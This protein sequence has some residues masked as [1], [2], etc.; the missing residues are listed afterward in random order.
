MSR[1][2]SQ[3]MM[4]PKLSHDEAVQYLVEYHFGRLSPALNA[5][6]EAHV[7]DC[8]LCQRQ[9]LAHA[10]TEKRD[11]AR[12]IKRIR[13]GK[14]RIT[15][16]G[17]NF[18]VLLA[19]LA[20]A[21]L[22]VYQLTR[23]TSISFAALFGHSGGPGGSH[24]IASPPAARTLTPRLTFDV[25]SRGTVALA[26]SPDGKMVAGSMMQGNSPAVVL[27]NAANG[28]SDTTLTWPG[29]SVPGAVSWSPD[30]EKVVATDGSMI[31][32]WLLPDAAPAWTAPVP[33]AIALRTYDAQTGNIAQSPAPATA[34]ANGTFLLW[35]ADGQVTSAP[36]GAAGPSGV[37]APGTPLIGLWQSSG[38]H[39]VPDGNGGVRVGIS[40]ADVAGHS[41]LVSWSPDS[42]YVMWAAI[43]QHLALTGSDSGISTPNPVVAA[44]AQALAR[45]GSGDAL[46]WFSPDGRTLAACDRETAGANLQIYDIATGAV[47]SEVSNAC[48]HLTASSLAWD[49][50]GSTFSLAVHGQPIM[51]YDG[52]NAKGA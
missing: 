31:G 49:G 47:L 22:G 50:P 32:V 12:Q 14:R 6:V 7:H 1:R 21:Q 36:A 2:K 15:R 35:G 29:K 43:S 33:P 25:P 28:T 34:F 37:V 11:I 9:G 42:H 3:R 26:V 39:L 18:I 13:P 48:D 24:P 17:R 30:G 44:I 51:D 46:V 23:S 5:A 19:L 45:S 41:A 4:V 10:A 16:R 27:W 8:R 38:T 52:R 40:S 20:I